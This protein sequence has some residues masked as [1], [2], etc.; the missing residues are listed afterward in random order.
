MIKKG[1]LIV[2]ALLLAVSALSG[3]SFSIPAKTGN[4]EG[5]QSGET[6]VLQEAEQIAADL[7]EAVMVYDLATI[8]KYSILDSAACEAILADILAE[9]K[10]N[11]GKY[12]WDGVICSSFGDFVEKYDTEMKRAYEKLEIT[13]TNAAFYD[14]TDVLSDANAR[15][16]LNRSAD[17]AALYEEAVSKLDIE[18]VAVID[19]SVVFRDESVVGKNNETVTYE[20]ESATMTVYLVCV[21]DQWKSYSPTLAGTLPPLGHFPRYVATAE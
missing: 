10:T 21:N 15:E 9:I 6:A 19:F 17:S 7:A 8:K 2:F 20:E 4:N 16:L 11:D 1:I 3:C 12:D 13:V 18:R 5:G 14:S